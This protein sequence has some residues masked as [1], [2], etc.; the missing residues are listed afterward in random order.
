[1]S[2]NHTLTEQELRSV[3][4]FNPHLHSHYSLLDGVGTVG[5]H[6]KRSFEC[7]HAGCAITDHGTMASAIELYQKTRDKDF[8]EHEVKTRDPFPGVIGVELYIT[9]DVSVRDDSNKYNHITV[10]AKDFKGYENLSYLTSIASSPDHYYYR[11]RVSLAELKQYSEGLIATSGCVI[12]M[13]PQAILNMTG[14]EEELLKQFID[15]FGSDFYLEIHLTDIRH[16][17]DRKSKKHEDQGFN[18][19]EIVN[20][21]L[22][23]LGRKHGVKCVIAQDAHMPNKQD[24]AIQSIMIANSPSGKDGWHFK[25]AYYTRTVAEMY[26]QLKQVMPFISDTDFLNYCENS[27]EV[28]NKCKDLTLDFKPIL[29]RVK[30]ESNPVNQ[31]EGFEGILDNLSHVFSE[32]DPEFEA[33]I[34]LSKNDVSLRTTLKTIIRNAKIDLLDDRYRERLKQEISTIQYNGRIKLLDYFLLLEDV[35]RRVTEKGLLRGYGRGSGA[36]SLICYA[37]DITDCDPLIYGLL[38]E[39]FL[40]KNRIGGL[41]FEFNELQDTS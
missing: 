17:W 35:S 38:F 28:L 30:F 40:T 39:R 24:H 13:I 4:Y 3:R 19:Q 36:G 6:I 33:I 41:T 26:E 25:D 14:R 5:A 18:P 27:I 8:L 11:P 16:K 21:R 2:Q 29:P 9:E 15:I 23:E 7:G 10:L 22:I 31:D 20:I 34:K 12:G 32:L 1:M 37:L